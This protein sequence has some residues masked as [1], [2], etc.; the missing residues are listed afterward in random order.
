MSTLEM[1]TKDNT[2]LPS[3]KLAFSVLHKMI[4]TWG[5]PDVVSANGT[6]TGTAPEPSLPGFDRFMI[7]RFSPLVWALPSDQAFQPK[8][9]QSKQALGEAA[10]MQRAIFAKTGQNYATYLQDVEFKR[11]GIEG[12]TASEYLEAL[13]AP[14]VKEFRQY[15]Q[16]YSRAMS[17]TFPCLSFTEPGP[18]V[19]VTPMTYALRWNTMALLTLL[20][21]AAIVYYRH[22]LESKVFANRAHKLSTSQGAQR[23]LSR[24]QQIVEDW[25]KCMA[26]K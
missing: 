6:L 4:T 24:I 23:R 16:V 26:W 9:A 7:E 3:V 18:E 13:S 25:R 8:D 17:S 20:C 19:A 12:V 15:F 11:V 21:C 14:D 2:D 5:G 10:A 1:F 22:I